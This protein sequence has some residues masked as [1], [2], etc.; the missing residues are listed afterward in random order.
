MPEDLLTRQDLIEIVEKASSLA[1]RPGDCFVPADDLW[2]DSAV[3]SRLEAW[4]QAAA[5][6]DR[7]RFRRR[8]AYDGLNEET[9]KRLLY[10]VRLKPGAPLPDWTGLLNDAVRE[11]AL[12]ASIA[13]DSVESAES[14][15]DQQEPVP[16]E[17][18]LTPFVIIARRRLESLAG[19]ISGQL[20]A[21]AQTALERSLLKSLAY[22]AAQSLHLEFSLLR[23]QALPPAA[24]LFEQLLDSDRRSLYGEFV[25]NMLDGGLTPFF[26]EYAV[27]ARL[28]AVKA[29]FWI[30][31]NA[32]FLSRLA[33]DRAEIQRVFGEK[34]EL[35]EVKE[36]Q[37]VLSDQHRGGRTVV[38]LVFASGLKLIYKPK[39]LGVEEAAFKLLAWMN[40]QGVPLPFKILKLLNRSTHGWIEYVE[41]LPCQT[42]AEARRYYQRAGM[43]LGL[44][45][46]LDGTDCHNENIIASG[47]HPVLV[48]METL[49]QHQVGPGCK[50]GTAE[51][52]ALAF[53]RLRNSVLQ[54]GL[55]PTWLFG[56]DRRAAYDVSGLGG[57]GGQDLPFRS[58]RW[59]SVNT[60]DMALKIETHKLKP[61]ANTPELNSVP[62]AIKDY[63]DEVVAG[64]REMY[65]FLEQ[66]QSA[67]LE[68]GS[69]L[70][71]LSRQQVRFIYRNTSVYGSILR[72]LLNP[73]YLRDGAD[74]SIA[75]DLLARAQVDAEDVSPQPADNSANAA[76][77]FWPLL[78]AEKRAMEQGDI[79]FFITRSD[80]ADLPAT[81]GAVIKDC[82]AGPSFTMAATRIRELDS[83]DLN[84]QTGYIRAALYT[85]HTHAADPRPEAA[86]GQAEQN[87]QIIEA[88]PLTQAELVRHA[89]GIAE[90][91]Q[92][93]AICAPDGSA[94]WI[95][96]QLLAEAG[97]YQLQP[98]SY[99]L[100]DGASGIALFLAAMEKVS[101]G[102]GW[103]ELALAALQ[104]LRH[105]LRNPEKSQTMADRLGI[106]GATGL[107]SVLYA[108]TRTGQLLNAADLLEEAQLAVNLITVDRIASDRS[109]DVMSGTAGAIL[110]LLA[111]HQ[112]SGGPEVLE[113]AVA[114]GRHL[115]SHRQS[116]EA[117][118]AW[119]T[120]GGKL[121]TGFS[122][123][124][125]GI[126]Y[127]LLRLYEVT[128]AAEL[129]DAAAAA[130]AFEHDYFSAEAGNWRDLREGDSGWPAFMT[131]W[132]HGAPGI[133][134]ARLGGINLYD[135]SMVRQDIAAALSTTQK[136]GLQELDHLCCGNLGRAEVLLT[137][138]R[139]LQR[140]EL[141]TVASG[142]ASQV[143]ARADRAGGYLLNPGLS[144][145]VF[146][147][148]LFQGISGVGYALLRL[149]C[150]DLLPCVLMWE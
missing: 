97:R 133:G 90:E 111:V 126:A 99:N 86:K 69:P 1:E 94:T 2:A 119:A 98:A 128:G 45:Y 58:M 145:E 39:D 53:R 130:I 27:L 9:A 75:L 95:A 20:S 71:G 101:G 67:I 10:P 120:L 109:Y 42:S 32:E 148:G 22:C 131:S 55:L 121:L 125:A 105:A 56:K 91:L 47:E 44:V 28:L 34:D 63:I 50:S 149:A 52:Q 78:A 122:H 68:P 65:T 114:C 74:R 38:G 118:Q 103:R 33:A 73:K 93:L 83:A 8:L 29:S 18:I 4:R 43:L 62:L 35:G 113:K 51:S 21:G 96:P 150:P 19:K 77:L 17:E 80:S 141:S 137:A 49:L 7:D 37:P 15:L 76:P 110:G 36:I 117:G 13:E 140:P 60:D 115:L 30:E 16:F 66:H 92:K 14:F 85:R 139:R 24:L 138:S 124:A 48:D 129:R 123:G 132:C 64:F 70:Y 84:R 82:F 134:L 31:T 23:R 89:V 112:A 25:S 135:S 81:P 108:L 106:G 104:P 142:L 143:L 11:A 57:E 116:S 59:I 72:E 127:A 87:P 26:K 61:Q 79:P 46:V 100:Y 40:A 146:M 41:H 136:L 88:G 54:T 102:S 144:G 5:N 3:D 6:G 107:G 147:P 12:S